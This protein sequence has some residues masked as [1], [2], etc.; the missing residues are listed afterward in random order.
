MLDAVRFRRDYDHAS[1]QGIHSRP[2]EASIWRSGQLRPSMLKHFAQPRNK[3]I[4]PGPYED[5]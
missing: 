2:V 4:N 5:F 3:I 1:R